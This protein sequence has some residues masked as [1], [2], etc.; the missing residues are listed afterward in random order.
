[1]ENV[2]FSII[3]NDL[4]WNSESDQA[5]D[6][7]LLLDKRSSISSEA[8]SAGVFSDEAHEIFARQQQ[9]QILW[10]LE[11]IEETLAAAPGGKHVLEM[12]R[13]GRFLDLMADSGDWDCNLALICC[14][15]FGSLENIQYL[16][17]HYSY[18]VDP[19]VADTRGRTPLHFA[20]SRANAS[21]AKVLLDRGADPNRWDSKK[22][23][24]ALHCSA[25]SKSVECILLLLR[26]KA[27]INIGI[28]KRSALHYAIDVNAVDCVEILLKYGADPNTPQ[29]YTE[30]PLHT[31]SAAGFAKCVQL[32]LNHNADVR[33]QFGEGKVTALHLAAENDYVECARLLLEHRADVDCRNASHQT[34][35]HLACLSQSIGT[36]EVLISYGANVNAVYRDGRTALHAAIVKQSRCLDCCNALLKAGADVNKADNYG[37]TPLHIAALN[38]FSSCVYTFIEHGADITA[39]TDGHVSALSFIVRRT[40]EIIPKL[41]QK[42]DR[43]IKA[44]DHEIGDVDCQIKLDF[45]LLVPSS[46]ME[47]GETELLLSLI[48]VGQKRILMHP[49]CETFLFLKWRR[50]RKFFLMSLAYHTFFVLL[51]TLYTCS[52]YVR[53]CK[54]GEV[55]VAPGYVSTVGYLVIILNLIL[56]GKEVF[57][58]AHGLH[59]YAKYWENWLQWTIVFGVLLCVSPEILRTG[60]LL[61]V[62][63]WQHHVAAVV[64]L[65][66]WLELMMLVGR[67]PM[68]GVYVQMFTKVAFNFAK[69][70]LAYICLLVAFGLSFA[71]LFNDYPAFENITWSFLK[72]ITMMSGELEFEDIFYGDYAVKFPVT[73]HIIFLS[74]VLLVTVILTNLMVG[75]AV[76]DIQGLQ[77]SAT[78]DRLV[79][80]A[81]LVSRLESLF[82][83]RLLRSAPT[84]LIQLCKRSALLRTSRDK[85]Q[86][87]IRP[88]DPRDNQLPEDIKLNVYKLVAER[89]DRNQS[90]RRRQ[91]EDNYNIF[92]RSL[93]RQQNTFQRDSP[94]P[95]PV[96]ASPKKTPQNIF[97]MHELLRPR[98]ATNVPQQLRQE[99]EGTVKM[100]NQ[101]N[102][103]FAVQAEVQAIK[104]QLGELVAKFE[105]F[106]ENA[107]RKLNYSADELCRLRQQSQSGQSVVSSHNRHHR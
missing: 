75:L 33:S 31:A 74:F 17:K 62:P 104:T 52:V 7:D 60:D 22:E 71:V 97:H 77:V 32:L 20:C 8:N 48:E 92:S 73:A 86:F 70:L 26:R 100:K 83:S 65:L 11:E 47:R 90:L 96:M 38:E 56:L 15:A 55:C 102:G 10:E 82:F 93:Q 91:F 87:T 13:S 98:S 61:G 76:S 67:F 19:N 45:R 89:R 53:C 27:N 94:Q 16:L 79:R 81:E 24:T 3:E 54:D 78:L 44:N 105:R 95:E 42:L 6:E 84:N 28:E 12:V 30:T 68:F 29:V 85:L 69:F 101:A 59:G 64:I 107:T 9:N 2:R 103:L 57:Q 4:K 50:I 1:M 41:M 49:L 66:V 23:V 39:R 25:S 36:V 58:M 43:S 80:Q 5:A 63:V 14:S 18:S 21:I 72:S 40:P 88:N 34:P 51:F 99:Q 37:Y 46:S 35:L 106:S